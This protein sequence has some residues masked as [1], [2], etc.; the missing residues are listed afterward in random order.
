MKNIQ[1]I[2]TCVLLLSSGL[3]AQEKK[4]Q[5]HIWGISASGQIRNL[6]SSSSRIIYL[7]IQTEYQ[8]R[9]RER[10]SIG[11]TAQYYHAEAG[12][13][14]KT[15]QAKF[16]PEMRYWFR[17][18]NTSLQPYVFMNFGMIAGSGEFAERPINYIG[19]SGAI[20][21]GMIG[22]INDSWGVHAK[23]DVLSIGS[24]GTTY[25]TFDPRLHIGI[26]YR[27]GQ[28]LKKDSSK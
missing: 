9:F 8:W 17:M 7:T 13:Y 4:P 23:L 10:F 20:G 25:R 3:Q 2:T 24:G 19:Y 1:L 5:E 28:Q 18:K 12:N 15:Y 21:V 16:T 14:F 22:W 27:P 6:F 11:A 26:V